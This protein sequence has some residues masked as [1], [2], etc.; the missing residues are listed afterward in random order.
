MSH[1]DCPAVA[2]AKDMRKREKVERERQKQR[3]GWGDSMRCLATSVRFQQMTVAAAV[4]ELI[5]NGC[6]DPEV[7]R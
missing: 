7:L 3:L 6:L 5:D 2:Y 4:A 1:Q